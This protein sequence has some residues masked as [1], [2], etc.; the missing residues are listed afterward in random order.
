MTE[1]DYDA[2]YD[3]YMASRETEDSRELDAAALAALD[4]SPERE[5]TPWFTTGGE[6]FKAIRTG[7][8]GEFVIR[9]ESEYDPAEFGN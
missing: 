4:A 5:V 6:R 2:A 7:G 1:Y 3:A 9:H 8:D